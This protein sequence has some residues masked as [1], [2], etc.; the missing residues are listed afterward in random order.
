MADNTSM[1]LR[2]QKILNELKDVMS[3]LGGLECDK[4]ADQATFLELGFDSLFLAQMTTV[5]R[6]K[7][8]VNVT[9]R[10]LLE[11]APSPKALAIY[12]DSRLPLEEPPPSKPQPAVV[13]VMP[14]PVPAPEPP[15]P[16]IPPPLRSLES[17]ATVIPCAASS[18]TGK[19]PKSGVLFERLMSQQLQVMERQ[20]EVLKYCQKSPGIQDTPRVVSVNQSNGH[21][22]EAPLNG[23]PQDASLQPAAPFST[24]AVP[25]EAPRFGPWKPID[26]SAN[27]SL[28]PQQRKHLEELILRYTARTQKSKELTVLHRPHLADPRVV[29]GF[30]TEWKE[31]VYPIVSVRSAGSKLWDI[32]GNEYV[33]M[34]MGFG[35]ALFGHSPDFVV[36]ALEDQIKTGIEIG[37]QSPLVGEVARLVCDFTGMERATFCNT[38]SEAVL[39]ALRVARTVTGRN[40]IAL[41]AGS[42]HGIFDE[43]L[44]RPTRDGCKPV[45]VA[46]GIPSHM[47]Q[48]VLVLRYGDPESLNIV[49]KHADELAA[50]L[51]EPV[52]SRH[53]DLQ[54]KEFLQGLRALTAQS[55][56]ALIFDE[57]I[58]GFRLHSGGAQAWFGVQADLATY[59]KAL[60]GGL[61][62]GAVAG[63]ARFMDALDGGQWNFGD[64]S[65][66]EASVTYFAGTFVRHPL[67]I[68]AAAA[69]LRHLQQTGPQLY[70]SLNDRASRLAKDLNRHF[71]EDCI[72]IRIQQCGS[73][74]CVSFTQETRFTSLFFYYLREKGIH[75]W[76]GRPTFISTAHTN[77]DLAF[78]VRAMRESAEE[79]RRG[80]FFP[81]AGPGRKVTQE[82]LNDSP[83]SYG[84]ACPAASRIEPT[85][86]STAPASVSHP[87]PLTEA[88]ME[89]W[90]ATQ[91]GNDASRAFNENILLQFKGTLDI[92]AMRWAVQ[93]TVERHEALRTVFSA[94]GNFQRVNPFAPIDIPLMDLSQLVEE[95][96]KIRFEDLVRTEVQHPFDLINGPL[97]RVK[98]FR[99]AKDEHFLLVS[100]HH[101]ICDGW[102]IHVL[103]SD[104]S[105]FYE[106]A[107]N[108]QKVELS[109]PTPFREYAVWQ[110]EQQNKPEGVATERYW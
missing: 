36:R 68:A 79:M 19:T 83:D 11:E 66:P 3:D 80:G 10:Q 65:M 14:V 53:P 77:E 91:L 93:R 110:V 37:P 15:A 71:E 97:V 23:K 1:P 18:R 42:Y 108:S 29:A 89:I 39:A 52:Q 31:M 58:T 26:K 61:P 85:V 95:D 4:I 6:K 50:V 21:R 27:G 33:D 55:G 70:Q 94:D 24:D 99:L 12:I 56:I 98:I 54:P 104:L 63:K 8:G 60:G 69:V 5:Y 9:F 109:Q 106:S 57:V 17:L 2:Q 88:Q 22:I 102:S 30:R 105:A 20:L 107:C 72:P 32:D 46:P 45:P 49:R 67:A 35:P 74:F 103:L 87:Y 41:F 76:E 100:A 86:T 16:P 28:D 81:T 40:K 13:P 92:D 90:L 43:V 82:K 48:D 78:V 59:G 64:A 84:P 34:I 101:I 47:V 7:F 62:I 51:V 96:G 75:I 73:L 25:A 44:V 38:G